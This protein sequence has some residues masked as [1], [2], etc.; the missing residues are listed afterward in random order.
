[1]LN[2]YEICP[3]P[4]I[5]EGGLSDSAIYACHLENPFILKVYPSLLRL[6]KE[7]KALEKLSSFN[8][9]PKIL[10]CY[11]DNK[12]LTL[13]FQ[14]GTHLSECSEDSFEDYARVLQT[15]SQVHTLKSENKYYPFNQ[16]DH[17]WELVKKKPTPFYFVQAWERW[18]E[19]KQALA[20]F[21]ACLCHG[22]FHRKNVLIDEDHVSF[23]DWEEASYGDPFAD[24]VKLLLQ[25]PEH[26]EK[27]LLQ[28]YLS[29]TVTLEDQI[30]FDL[31]KQCMV[32]FSCLNRYLK[33]EG[34][35]DETLFFEQADFNFPTE[36]KMLSNAL[37]L[38]QNFLKQTH[39]PVF[40]H[41]LDWILM[42]S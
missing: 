18:Q 20:S 6:L 25:A 11:P 2:L 16:I 21:E 3:E 4:L 28:S 29:R 22:D 10:D 36:E 17:L 24:V 27:P 7:K 32:L 40:Q 12:A 34:T 9:I 23:I 30:H 39:S 14:K 15:L 41:Y 19:I 42:K 38:M 5:L 8:C 1:M 31:M 35:F 13:S 37:C 33:T 26:L